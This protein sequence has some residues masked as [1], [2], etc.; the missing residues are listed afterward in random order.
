M[1]V[2]VAVSVSVGVI[3]AVVVGV[4]VAATISVGAMVGVAVLWMRRSGRL[5]AVAYD[6]KK[7]PELSLPNNRWQGQGS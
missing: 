1:G 3:V 4:V 7:T 2:A 6:G 5:P